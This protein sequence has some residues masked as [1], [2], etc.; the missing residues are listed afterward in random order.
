M[1]KDEW[2][3]KV[4][5]TLDDCVTNFLYYDRKEDEDLPR[6]KIEE[7]IAKKEITVDELVEKFRSSLVRGL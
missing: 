7:M 2:R 5:C 1:D 4:L 6:G 3:E